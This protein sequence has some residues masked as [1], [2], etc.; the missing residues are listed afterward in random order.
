MI[1]EV[2][3]SSLAVDEGVPMTRPAK[4][5]AVRHR[6]NPV[7]EQAVEKFKN[8]RPGQSFF[9]PGAS[10]RDVDKLRKPFIQAGLGYASRQVDCDEIYQ[11]AG[12]RVWR[13]HGEYDEL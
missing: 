10:K 8:M 7:I 13:L 3:I 5:Q 6:R 11:T 4:R 2:D 1:D 9:V 12:V